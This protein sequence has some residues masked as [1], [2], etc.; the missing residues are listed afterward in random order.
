L[1]KLFDEVVE[2]VEDYVDEIAERAV[3]LGGTVEGTARSV[4][5][6]STLSEYPLQISTGKEHVA[7]LTA[8]LGSFGKNVR[9]AIAE[10]DRIGDADTTD[11]FTQISRGVDKWLWFVEAHSQAI[12]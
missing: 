3:E 12:A 4:A 6:R 11:L 8:V 1:H 9:A 2:A 10:S 7:A 5:K